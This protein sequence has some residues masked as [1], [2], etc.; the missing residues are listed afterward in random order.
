VAERAARR[1]V[2][3]ESRQTV[4]R[5]AGRTARRSVGLEATF[6]P[7]FLRLVTRLGDVEAGEKFEFVRARLA[8]ETRL[9][10]LA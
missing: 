10:R 1:S 4:D 3:V 8:V 6:E 7:L 2:D 5:V 9:S